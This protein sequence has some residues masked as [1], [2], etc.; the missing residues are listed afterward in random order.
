M[1]YVL[2]AAGSGKT[3]ILKAFVGKN[4]GGGIESGKHVPTTKVKTV[5]NS[6]ETGGGEK[7]LV[8]QEFGSNYESE[9]LRNSKKLALADVLIFVYDSSDTNSFSYISNL[10]QQY[11]LDDI[12]SLFVATKSDLDL[13]QQR[14]QVQPDTY[15]RKLNLRV[16]VA[17]S[18]KRG[19]LAGLF[20][21]ITSIAIHPLSSI[22]GGVSRQ[23]SLP[24]YLYSAAGIGALFASSFLI[25]KNLGKPNLW[26]WF[27]GMIGFSQSPST[28]VGGVGLKGR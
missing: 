21:T 5:V 8:L 16:P 18:V 13:A 28:S 1:G 4:K 6:V 11:K 9:M 25:W 26:K 3:S 27:R 20:D 15:C 23:S 19:Q 2:G 17:V 12:P 7:Y 24:L 22:P 14:H 10:R